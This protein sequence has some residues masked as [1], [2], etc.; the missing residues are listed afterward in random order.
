MAQE[1]CRHRSV[2]AVV[3]RQVEAGAQEL[4]ADSRP[5]GLFRSHLEATLL[6]AHVR[7]HAGWPEI[8]EHGWACS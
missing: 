6:P 2:R 3:G 1:L 7:T 8:S 4:K 5:P